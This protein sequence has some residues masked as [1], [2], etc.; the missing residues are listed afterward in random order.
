MTD[1]SV[2]TTDIAIIG[3]GTVGS[4]L[5]LGIAKRTEFDTTVIDANSLDTSEGHPGFDARVIALSRRTVE[6]LRDIGADV[7]EADAAP[8]H[9]IQV[10]D[11]GAAGL[12]QLE[13]REFELDAF[14]HVIALSE[15]GAMLS[16][17]VSKT[18]VNRLENT[19]VRAVHREQ[20]NVTLT[21]SDDTSL[22]A[23]LVVLADGG[24]SS[25]GEQLGFERI[26]HSYDQVA[27]I[28]NVSMSLPHN[29]KA[30]ERFTADGP[31]A[32]LPFNTPADER[33]RH[34]FS[35]VWTVSPDQAVALESMPDHA[36]IR[37][38]QKAFGYRHGRIVKAGERTSYPLSLR[39][40]DRLATHRVAVAGNAAQTLHPIAGQGFNLG[41]RDAMAMINCLHSVS[42]P[43]SYATLKNY[44]AERTGDRE[45][46]VWL[47]DTL[48]RSFSNQHFPLV[49]GRNLGL[50]AMDNLR[51]VQH[52]FVRQTT[53]YGPATT[54][55]KNHAKS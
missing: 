53:G 48:V 7:I 14:G 12:C 22:T 55:T 21:L 15:L 34:C 25:L 50:I 49:A 9:F 31:L 46:T 26:T 36:F 2:V 39:Q 19:T 1:K 8:I 28:C 20:E 45:Q 30:Y 29:N 41:L 33:G 11:K 24:R 42:D 52:A 38:L 17:A 37:A 54:G 16:C 4:A 5:A 13:S 32:F 18:A 6:E 3:G 35:V 10:S 47:T 40:T 23:K 27:V 51:T 43:G 44:T